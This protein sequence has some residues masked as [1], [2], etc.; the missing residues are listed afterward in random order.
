[1]FVLLVG[2]ALLVP[3]EEMRLDRRGLVSGRVSGKH[4]K[5]S[6]RLKEGMSEGVMIL[7]LL[8]SIH[9]RLQRYLTYLGRSMLTNCGGDEL[10]ED[11]VTLVLDLRSNSN[12][13]IATNNNNLSS[14]CKRASEI[15]LKLHKKPIIRG[16]VWAGSSP[17]VPIFHF[18]IALIKSSCSCGFSPQPILSFIT[19]APTLDML[20]PAQTRAVD[21]VTNR[22]LTPDLGP[23]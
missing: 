15:E 1:M 14:N 21:I 7:E 12:M 8:R 22:A 13:Q 19:P 2:L 23:K 5:V 3:V 18:W 6:A 9:Q 20:G 17:I 4:T 11:H 16:E 10:L